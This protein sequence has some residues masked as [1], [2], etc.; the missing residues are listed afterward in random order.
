MNF[1]YKQHA[2]HFLCPKSNNT[3]ALIS[4]LLYVSLET[5]LIVSHDH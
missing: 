1:Q 4:Y 2:V 5:S 3:I